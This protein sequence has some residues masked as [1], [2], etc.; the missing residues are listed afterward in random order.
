[1]NED[2]V[3]G[4]LTF[5]LR[6]GGSTASAAATHLSLA[7]QETPEFLRSHNSDG[8]AVPSA[9]GRR[10]GARPQGVDHI[11]PRVYD[12]CLNATLET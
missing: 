2:V 11:A 7:K 4:C 6:Q 8:P 3:C 9:V 5:Y 10:L 12:W 1:M